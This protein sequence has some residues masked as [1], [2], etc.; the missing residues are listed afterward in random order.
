MGL[1]YRLNEERLA[2]E[3]TPSVQRDLD[4][5][6]I[7]I[8]GARKSMEDAH[9]AILRLL[10]IKTNFVSYFAIFDGYGGSTVSKFCQD[11]MH[12][13]LI[14]SFATTDDPVEALKTTF[15]ETDKQFLEK[16]EK[17]STQGGSTATIALIFGDHLYVANAGDSEAVLSRSGKAI[18][19]TTVHNMQRN[20]AEEHRI[21]KLGG[22]IYHKRLGHPLWNPAIVSI[23]VTRAIGDLFFKSEKFTTS[24][25][26]GLT[27][28]PDIYQTPLTS[29]EEFL[30]VACDGL[31]AVVSAQEA[32][33]FVTNG[34]KETTNAQVVAQ[35][36][37]NYAAEKGSL[38]NITVMIITF[39]NR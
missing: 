29:S 11:N 19:V 33:D 37:A 14:N 3:K 12:Q 10:K 20:A 24:K 7:G 15:A 8:Q 6:V 5:G 1:Q 2:E 22:I 4:F 31:W 38:D 35:D 27:S 34:M 36:L 32:V 16:A 28:I 23:G 13:V 39:H 9:I 17:E 21:K 18:P 30:I 26:T 25:P